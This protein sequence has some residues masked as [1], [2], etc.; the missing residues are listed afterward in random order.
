MVNDILS[1]FKSYE[2]VNMP[3][4]QNTSTNTLSKFSSTSVEDINH[5]LIQET[6]EKPDI[7]TIVI[8]TAVT[9]GTTKPPWITLIMVYIVNR[10]LREGS[11]D[12][13]LVK[14]KTC[15]YLIIR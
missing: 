14:R 13:N 3:K 6:L 1:L 12:A 7:S 15:S 11:L 10:T 5:S 2:I 9:T 8:V 4:E